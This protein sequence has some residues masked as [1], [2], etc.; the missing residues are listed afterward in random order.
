VNPIRA[1]HLKT[2]NHETFF[3]LFHA[4][5]S[6]RTR[7]INRL[8][9]RAGHFGNCILLLF[10]LNFTP[11]QTTKH[12]TNAT[13]QESPIIAH[14]RGITASITKRIVTNATDQAKLTRVNISSMIM[15]NY[16][17]RFFNLCPRTFKRKATKK[18]VQAYDQRHALQIIN[19]HENLIISIIKTS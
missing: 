18:T 12:A 19:R 15:N 14:L 17:V 3:Y 9:L 7:I 5:Q 4:P 16:E 6:R 1:K 2:S 13:V 8:I 11:W 10:N